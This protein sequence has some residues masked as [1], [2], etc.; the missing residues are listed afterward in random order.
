MRE[1]LLPE[2][3][4]IFDILTRPAPDLS[5]KERDEVKKV[6]RELLQ[7][8]KSLLSL[9][10]KQTAAGR[11]TVKIAIEE[12]LDGGLPRAYDK[13]MFESKVKALFQHIYE[14]GSAA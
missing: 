8:V 14:T 4:V 11:A 6:T 5:E 2:E 13:P 9:N 1:H 3:L 10:W 12:T 7:R